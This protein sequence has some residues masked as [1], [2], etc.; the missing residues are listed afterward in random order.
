VT[1]INLVRTITTTKTKMPPVK[2]GKA[3]PVKK[4]APAPKRKKAGG[5]KVGRKDKRQKESLDQNTRGSDI[6]EDDE[7]PAE[8]QDFSDNASDAADDLVDS[9]D[10]DEG[11]DESLVEEEILP[12]SG[13]SKPKPAM[14]PTEKLKE[15]NSGLD[16][17]IVKY[18]VRGEQVLHML[19]SIMHSLSVNRRWFI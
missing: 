6:E 1:M 10:S 8:D 15:S 13:R 7:N 17:A 18:G 11:D 14:K 4:A 5:K 9:E 19:Y 3:A 12:K 2:K 16:A